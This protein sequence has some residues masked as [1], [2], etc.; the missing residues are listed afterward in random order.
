MHLVALA[1]VLVSLAAV[2]PYV[3]GDGNGYY[4]WLASAVVDRDLEFRNQYAHAEPLF[5][6]RYF[7]AD[8]QPRPDVLTPSG[9]MENQWSVGPALLW[10]PWFLA[11]HAGVT[12]A[13]RGGSEIAADGYT[14]PYRWACA[15]GTVI[16]GWM[17]V[18]L[19]RRAAVAVGVAPRSAS[20][21]AAAVW[22]AGPLPVYQYFLPFHVHALAAF[23]VSLYLWYWLTRRPL[24]TLRSW[25]VWGAAAG[26]MTVVYQ[27]N[28][29]LLLV[30]PF[31]I[32][33]MRAAKPSAPVWAAL[34]AGGAGAL[35]P[36]VP[37]LAGKAIV[38]G[39]PFTTGYR[40]RFFWATPRML[41]TAWSTEHGLFLWTPILLA[42]V[43]GLFTLTRRRDVVIFTAVFAVFFYAVASFE[44]WHGVSSFGN[45]FFL[46]LTAVFVIGLGALMHKLHQHASWSTPGVLAVCALLALWNA[47]LAFQW[48]TNLIPTRG[49]IDFGL[50]AVQQFTA[51]PEH[52]AAFARQYFSD[53]AAV[54]SA[55]EQRDASEWRAGRDP[56]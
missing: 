19:A 55:I 27:L 33:E 42:C 45:R 53:R 48:G 28:A 30:V 8:G 23:S 15:I 7:D 37:Q 18:T 51:A 20:I 2:N 52:A 21:A 40:D 5:R 3:H 26:L 50:V 44:N 13:R 16:Y 32:L 43:V 47:G 17:G 38:Y 4:A 31:A 12:V 36:W 22:A 6:D 46:S 34:A 1:A 35:M 41:E 14:W 49:P 25:A 54:M 24:V 9:R 39:T 11:A 29:V 10:A 56:R